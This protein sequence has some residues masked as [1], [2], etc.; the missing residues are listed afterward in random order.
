MV[1]GGKLINVIIMLNVLLLNGKRFVF[2]M[3]NTVK[4]LDFLLL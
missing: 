4:I 3:V 1:T 2:N